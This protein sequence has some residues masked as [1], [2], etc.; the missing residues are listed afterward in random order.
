MLLLL[1]SSAAR[2][3]PGAGIAYL[4]QPGHLRRLRAS[5]FTT[6]SVSSARCRSKAMLPDASS[7]SSAISTSPDALTGSATVIGGNAVV[8]SQ[9]R[10]GG[11]ALVVG[12]QCGLR[13][14][15]VDLRQ[16]VGHRRPSLAGR[17]PARSIHASRVLSPDLL[18][19]D[20][21]SLHFCC[22]RSC[23]FRDRRRRSEP[24][25]SCS[26]K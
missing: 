22:C 13:D 10:I 11:N 24:D 25:K 2:S 16:R 6:P 17:R 3:C 9:A 12:R 26:G 4:F 23:S 8:D 21:R 20:W 18:L 1:L 5:R 15:R 19:G 7:F 14:R